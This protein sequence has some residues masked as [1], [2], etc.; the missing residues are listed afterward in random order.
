MMK[1]ATLVQCRGDALGAAQA[2]SNLPS[3]LTDGG[4]PAVCTLHSAVACVPALP[5][6]RASVHCGA[7]QSVF[8]ASAVTSAVAH[9]AQLCCSLRRCAHAALHF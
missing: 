8:R 1:L 7:V 3:P 4:T 5:A 2:A 9:T 6:D